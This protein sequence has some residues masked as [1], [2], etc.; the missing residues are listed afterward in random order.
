MHKQKSAALFCQTFLS[1]PIQWNLF[2]Y[3]LFYPRI[4]SINYT[5]EALTNQIPEYNQFAHKP[6][7]PRSSHK[8]EHVYFHFAA[9]G[10]TSLILGK[11]EA[12]EHSP[13]AAPI[14]RAL[15]PAHYYPIF[16]APRSTPPFANP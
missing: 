10:K 6:F 12:F 15:L 3:R 16:L 1:M 11:N 8:L 14:L 2:L 4:L 7:R 9:A 5:A 13:H